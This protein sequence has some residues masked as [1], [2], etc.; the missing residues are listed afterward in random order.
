[1]REIECSGKAERGLTREKNECRAT[2]QSGAFDSSREAMPQ[3]SPAR[4]CGYV[5]T[6]GTSPVG[7]AR[8]VWV[9]EFG[10]APPSSVLTQSGQNYKRE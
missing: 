7:T 9:S 2:T 8:V 10:H 6:K 5:Q 3:D 4:E 1:M